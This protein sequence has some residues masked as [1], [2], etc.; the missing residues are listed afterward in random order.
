MTLVAGGMAL[1]MLS[2]CHRSNNRNTGM[3]GTSS[4][5][6]VNSENIQPERLDNWADLRR[7]D[8]KIHVKR[9][10]TLAMQT[11][12][13][14]LTA[15]DAAVQHE[16]DYSVTSLVKEELPPLPQGMINMTAAT[17]GYRLL[18]GGEHF[19]PYAELRMAYDPERL[20]E[21]YTPDDI[22][23]SF[24][25][26]A[27][28]AWVRLE[29]VEVD[30]IHHEIVSLTTH[31]TD[32]INELLKAPEM[33]ETQAF[34]PTAMNDLEAVSPM[35]GLTTI[36][37]PTAN[38]N[39][40]ANVSYPI[41]IPAGRG[42]MQPSLALNYSS[43]GGSSANY[44]ESISQ[45]HWEWGNMTGS[46]AINGFNNVIIR[47]SQTGNQA[48]VTMHKLDYSA[49]LYQGTYTYSSG[50]GTMALEDRDSHEPASATFSIN[51]NTLTLKMNGASYPLAKQ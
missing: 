15:I 12:G 33:P 36:Q 48:N 47:F 51:G 49:N 50:N 41:V 40:T 14:M 38:N 25:D 23:T 24:Y 8:V 18:P 13:M 37:P 29:R 11:E 44:P 22:Y 28:L 46:E 3:E 20:P 19:L 16:A 27:T 39:G 45:T 21:G 34:V 4:V 7:P 10:Q 1:A 32:F 35:D 9:G 31:F 2:A 42:G 26:T 17:A 5:T 30:T 43:G 6:Q